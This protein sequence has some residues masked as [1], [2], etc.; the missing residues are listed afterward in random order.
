MIDGGKKQMDQSEGFV[1][2]VVSSYS[3]IFN[4]ERRNPLAIS[5]I[6]TDLMI[7]ILVAA[8][9]ADDTF[10]PLDAEVRIPFIRIPNE[11][12]EEQ[13]LYDQLKTMKN[14]L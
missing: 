4:A 5:N 7:E 8:M 3:G 10:I 2:S 11:C 1:T 6:S 13:V 14:E 9:E 12:P